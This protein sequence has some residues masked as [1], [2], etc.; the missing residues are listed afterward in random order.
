MDVENRLHAI[1]YADGGDLDVHFTALCVTWEK[2]NN[3]GGKMTDSQFC[4]IVLS[5]MP[6]SWNMLVSTLMSMK[7]SDEVIVQLTLHGLLLACD[8]PPSVTMPSQST[9]THTLT[10]QTQN[11]NHQCSTEVCSNPVYGHT[12]H[13]INRCFKPGGGMAGQYSLW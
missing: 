7:S 5:S 8:V 4:M 13:T 9:N 11:H 12:G 10:T 1:K 3:Q 6:K 2:V